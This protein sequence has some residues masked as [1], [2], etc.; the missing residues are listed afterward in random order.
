MKGG[1]INLGYLPH[2]KEES[3]ETQRDAEKNVQLQRNLGLFSGI[4]III[5]L[6]ADLSEECQ[7]NVLLTRDHHRVRYLGD[8]GFHHE[9]Q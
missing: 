9:V 4:S 3:Q 1:E 6:S 8:P 5:G 7:C 2:H